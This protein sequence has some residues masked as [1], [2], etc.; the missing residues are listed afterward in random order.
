MRTKSPTAGSTEDTDAAMS[1]IACSKDTGFT[2]AA[3]AAALQLPSLLLAAAAAVA[4]AGAERSAGCSAVKPAARACSRSALC[5]VK[6]TTVDYTVSQ[7]VQ[8]QPSINSSSCPTS[9]NSKLLSYYNSTVIANSCAAASSTA[10]YYP[11]QKSLVA[12]ESTLNCRCTYSCKRLCLLDGSHHSVQSSA[13]HP[14]V[15]QRCSQVPPRLLHS[16]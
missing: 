12:A 14:V 6:S 10:L 16:S 2:A 13:A 8:C 4:G 5:V 1:S 11:R 3:A 15:V 7:Q 9:P